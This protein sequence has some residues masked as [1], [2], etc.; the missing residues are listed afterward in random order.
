MDTQMVINT[1]IMLVAFFGGWFLRVMW[2]KV[3]DNDARINQMEILVAGTYVKREEF[4]KKID[5]MFNKL[6]K[7]VE[8]IDSCRADNRGSL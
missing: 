1:L 2:Q 8:K 4:D 3:N 7:I 5:A 6:D